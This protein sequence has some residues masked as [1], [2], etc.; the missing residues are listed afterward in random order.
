MSAVLQNLRKNLHRHPE[1][2]GAEE[3]TAKRIQDFLL[4]NSKPTDLITRLGGTGVAAVYEFGKDGS[5]VLIRCELDALPILEQ[6]TFEHRSQ[7]PGVSHKCGHDGH[8]AMV[9]GLASW[10][11]KQQF[12]A[13][14]VVLLFQPAEETGQGAAAL[15]EDQRMLKLSIDYAFALHNIPGEPLH[16]VLLMEPGFSAEVQSFAL[17]LKGKTAHAAEPEEGINPATTIAELIT[18]LATFN[19]TV[20]TTEHFA[21]LTPIHIHLG[22]KSYGVAPGA[23]ELHYTIRTWSQEQMQQ[24][25]S[26]IEQAV[27]NICQQQKLEYQLDWFEHFPASNNDSGCNLQIER[28]AQALDLPLRKMPHPF[29]FGED[30]GWFSHR[31][32]TGMFGLGAGKNTSTLHHADYDFPDALLESGMGMFREIISQLLGE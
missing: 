15:L 10:L 32:K 22:E 28:A 21:I 9:A 12:P 20:S 1:L 11:D 26:R 7:T 6:N 24:L 30:F 2:S 25:V 14:R 19:H 8:M 4:E 5:G 3:Q 16:S 18:E 27:T 29:R 17:Q 23:G 13:G 31:F